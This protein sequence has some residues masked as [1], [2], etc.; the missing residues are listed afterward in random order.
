MPWL[1]SRQEGQSQHP[2]FPASPWT[3][4][5]LTQPI[6]SMS[7]RVSHQTTVTP[8][9]PPKPFGNPAQLP[10]SSQNLLP[11]PLSRLGGLGLS[12]GNLEKGI[13]GMLWGTQQWDCPKLPGGGKGSMS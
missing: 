12:T 11:R 13:H 10:P 1:R 2:R 9:S 6:S 4:P 5:S 3:T 8:K 7:S